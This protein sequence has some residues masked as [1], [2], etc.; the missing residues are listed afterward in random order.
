MESV[1]VPNVFAFVSATAQFPGYY[2]GLLNLA[3]AGLVI[4]SASGG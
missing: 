3:A 2:P 4:P 1:D